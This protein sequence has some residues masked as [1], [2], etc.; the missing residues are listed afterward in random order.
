VANSFPATAIAN[1]GGIFIVDDRMGRTTLPG[2]AVYAHR[3]SDAPGTVR[4]S[5]VMKA[6]V[7]PPYADLPFLYPNLRYGDCSAKSF[8]RSNVWVAAQYINGG[9]DWAT[10]I[11]APY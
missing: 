9:G 3:R 1:D 6:G 10:T 8:D 4:P 11:A 7:A 2:N 5:T